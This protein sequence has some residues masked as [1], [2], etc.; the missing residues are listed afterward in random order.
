LAADGGPHVHIQAI[1][2]TP[3]LTD[4]ANPAVTGELYQGPV[5]MGPSSP[6][7]GPPESWPCFAPNAPCTSDPSGAMLIGEPTPVQSLAT[8]TTSAAPGC[9]QVYYTITIGSGSGNIDLGI[10]VKQGANTILDVPLTLAGSIPTGQSGYIYVITWD[11][12]GFGPG[13][14]P[15]GVT[16]ATPVAGAATITVSTKLSKQTVTGKFTINLQ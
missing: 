4:A 10:S 7:A 9:G 5:A 14:C 12:I 1:A 13:D 3:W 8:C 16:C 2:R 6:N 11:D 15:T